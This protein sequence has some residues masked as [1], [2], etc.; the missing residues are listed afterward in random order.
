MV[1][2]GENEGD[3][4]LIANTNINA[5]GLNPY[6]SIHWVGQPIFPVIVWDTKAD[7]KDEHSW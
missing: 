5:L 3:G 6:G 4:P 1:G 7:Y 2:A